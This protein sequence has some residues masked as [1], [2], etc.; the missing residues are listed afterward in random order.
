MVK[1]VSHDLLAPKGG[2]DTNIGVVILVKGLD[3]VKKSVMLIEAFKGTNGY[4]QA[5]G[6][7]KTFINKLGEQTE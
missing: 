4:L 2:E 6:I 5:T 3:R 1:Y 7:R